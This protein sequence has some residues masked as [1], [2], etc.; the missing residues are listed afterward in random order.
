MADRLIVKLRIRGAVQRVG[1][2]V[3][4]DR[5]CVAAR[6]EG[7]VRNRSDGSVEAVIAGPKA[8]VERM[9][10]ACGRGPDKALVKSVEAA[11]CAEEEL[12]LRTPGIAFD[13]LPTV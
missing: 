13:V 12:S 1:Y 8:G 7:W 4:T 3:W 2:R 10:D 5:M 6:L 11:P 9:I